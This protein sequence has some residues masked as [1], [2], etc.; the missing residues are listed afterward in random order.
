MGV[1]ITIDTLPVVAIG[2]DFGIYMFSRVK[3]EMAK[4][5]NYFDSSIN[6]GLLTTGTAILFSGLTMI[7]PL[8]FV[9]AYSSIKFQAQMSILI[10]VILFINMLWAITVHP[11]MIHYFRPNFFKESMKSKIVCEDANVPLNLTGGGGGA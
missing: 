1:G 2:V 8:V 5:G 7:I 3:E 9:G 4:C 6:D 11:I 10:G